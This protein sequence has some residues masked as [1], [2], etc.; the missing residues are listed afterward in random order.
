MAAQVGAASHAAA[1]LRLDFGETQRLLAALDH[2]A[3]LVRAQD[4]ARG[5]MRVSC[6]DSGVENPT[7]DLLGVL[8]EGLQDDAAWD[9]GD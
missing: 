1:A 5:G 8:E 4:V 7:C 2:G 3:G 6:C 9:L